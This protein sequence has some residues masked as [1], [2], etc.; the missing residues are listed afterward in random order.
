MSNRSLIALALVLLV[1]IVGWGIYNS[2]NQ[3]SKMNE[4]TPGIGGGPGNLTDPQATTPSRTQL[5]T[6]LNQHGIL[7]SNHLQTLY[8]GNNTSET[9]ANLDRNSQ[10]IANFMSQ[11]G[12]NREEFLKM[13]RQHITEYENYTN[14][15]RNNDTAG[16]DQA[17]DRLETASSNM[18]QMFNQIIPDVSADRAT[19]LTQEHIALTLSIID[20]HSRGDTS[21]KFSQIAEASLQATNFANELMDGLERSI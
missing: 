9:S 11:L 15:L 1:G 6:L 21:E 18:G 2:T 12:A 14:A 3:T 7:A 20:A 17:R 8:D 5:Q 10:D 16:A 4:F 13:W 19:Q